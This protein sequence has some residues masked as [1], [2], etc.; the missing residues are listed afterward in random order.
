MA[1]TTALPSAESLPLFEYV[2]GQ[3]NTQIL[4]DG[5]PPLARKITEYVVDA[6]KWPQQPAHLRTV[7]GI[8]TSGITTDNCGIC[9]LS[10]PA[11]P[12]APC[13]EA[14][15][16][17]VAAYG[18]RVTEIRDGTWGKGAFATEDIPARTW[19]GEYL[20]EIVPAGSRMSKEKHAYTFDVDGR[21][22]VE[23]REFRNWT[24][25]MNHH[26]IENVAAIS[27]TY[28][29]RYVVA[30]RTHRDIW[31]GEELFTWYG[32][33]YFA[34]NCMSCLCDAVD[35]AHIPDEDT[36]IAYWDMVRD[37]ELLRE[38]KEKQRERE[39]KE[40]ISAKVSKSSHA[41]TKFIRGAVVKTTTQ[42][43]MDKNKSDQ[44][45]HKLLK[46]CNLTLP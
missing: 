24:A 22:S 26:C 1:D 6:Q 3:G 38:R 18:D 11:C 13:V 28:G 32:G 5:P 17:R 45:N 10:G 40:S 43:K 7:D 27:Y 44:F 15:H 29:H 46:H 16:T 8:L 20:G 37:E 23:S 35:G 33:D 4:N 42:G 36:S 21:Y 30:F 12:G 19:L 31:K 2:D 14:F 25:F 9:G 41:G 34:S 39:A